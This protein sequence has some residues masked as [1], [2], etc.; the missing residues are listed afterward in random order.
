MIGIGAGIMFMPRGMRG[1]ASA[2]D[3]GYPDLVALKGG[4]IEVMFERGMGEIGG[5]GKFVSKGQSVLIKPNMSWDTIPEGGAN[6]SPGLVAAIARHCVDAGASRVVVM[7]H[8]IEYW[9]RSRNSSGIGDAIKSVGAVYAPSESAGYYQKISVD[10][11]TLR[12]TMI[13][14]A[15]LECDVLISA[16]VLKHHGGAGASISAKGLMG[17]IWNRGEYHSKGLQSCIADFLNARK[18]DL[19]VIDA[20]RVITRHGPRGG[21]LDDVTVMN[22]LLISP[23]VVA[24]DTA[25]SMMLGRKPGEIEHIRLAAE[26]GFGEMD[27]SKIRIKRIVM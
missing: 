1:L 5:M 6:T 2:A 27:L 11:R 12:E 15:L 7:D 19:N 17:C 21:T 24:A 16:P 3:E 9:E 8:S 22:S 26:A 25:G 10:G 23:D 4:T 13:H 14:E 18:P 20:D